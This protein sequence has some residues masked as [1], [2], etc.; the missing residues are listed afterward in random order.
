MK[1]E[2]VSE[3]NQNLHTIFF[4]LDEENNN[5]SFFPENMPFKRI[6]FL[7]HK[8]GLDKKYRQKWWR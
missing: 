7:A 6:A 2:C 8:S 3:R 5:S 1:V 4:I